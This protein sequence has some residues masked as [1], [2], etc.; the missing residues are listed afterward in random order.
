M[1]LAYLATT[2]WVRATSIAGD[3]ITWLN[4]FTTTLCNPK[5]MLFAFVLLP[6]SG[7]ER[8]TPFLLCLLLLIPAAGSSWVLLG[9]TLHG[10]GGTRGST[11]IRRVGSLA[12]AV[13]SVLLFSKGLTQLVR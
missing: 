4:V 5:A 6:E 13:F 1:Y 11:L 3:T 2:L 12:L 10:R 9:G 7:S 8:L